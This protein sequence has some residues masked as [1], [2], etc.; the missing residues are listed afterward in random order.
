MQGQPVCEYY[1][2]YGLCKYGPSCKFDHPMEGYSST[3][4][5][6]PIIHSPWLSYQK[7]PSLVAL[8]ETSSSE[9]SKFTDWIRKGDTNH[10]NQDSN[11]RDL[12]DMPGRSDS[13]PHSS[14]ASSEI[15]H[16]E[17]D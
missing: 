16:N 1:T 13:R 11:T 17:S 6:P 3:L 5:S 14:K 12:G 2:L 4:P 7:T 10:R 8:S 9:S 15:T